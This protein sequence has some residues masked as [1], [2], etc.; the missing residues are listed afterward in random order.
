MR[1]AAES[2]MMVPAFR[3]AWETYRVPGT[4]FAEFIDGIAAA[5]PDAS[6]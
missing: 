1:S 6:R 3:A 5:V 2:M 4:H